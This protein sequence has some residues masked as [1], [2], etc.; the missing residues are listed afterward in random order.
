M[1]SFSAPL[2]R[3]LDRPLPQGIAKTRAA[4]WTFFFLAAVFLAWPVWRLGFEF[5][6]NRNEPWNA[7]FADAV[8]NGAPLY[9]GA[10]ELIANNYPPL[11]FYLVALA[12]KLTH[13]TII[14]GRLISLASTFVLA[15]SAG[16]CVRALGGSR[17]AAAFG[18]GLL[19]ATFSRFCLR[20]VGVNDPTLLAL[21][22]MGLGLAFFLFRQRAGR[23]VEPAIALL[24]L[25]G[26]V[27]HNMAV[28]PAAALIWLAFGNWR[29]ALRAAIFAAALI[30][31]GLAVC[32]FAF[33]PNFAQQML[34]PREITIAHMLSGLN[35]PQWVAPTIIFWGLWAWPNRKNPAAR[36][37]ALLLALAYASGLVQAAGAGVVYNAY[38]ELFF[39][40]AVAAALAYEGIA[41]TALARRIGVALAQTAMIAALVVRLIASQD[42][43]QFLVIASPS[44]RE[45]ARQYEASTLAEVARVREIPGPVVCTAMTVC[46]RAGKPFVYDGFW[47]SQFVAKGRWTAEAV[48]DA[49]RRRG[50]RFEE[51]PD[52]VTLDKKRLF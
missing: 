24:V 5:E 25:A 32:A 46:Y 1:S 41:T 27:K 48:A 10:D 22:L 7:W 29:A 39:A 51:M 16:L 4:V 6:I 17:I 19:L 34:I 12:S 8:L 13:D 43:E 35:K 14:A 26:F 20:Y 49:V 2:G 18:A 44:F 33:G 50:I 31:A 23:A 28:L 36:F 11:S 42:L 21:A 15:L 40:S 3:S 37:T 9:P 52:R 30:A 38:F 45:E 47:V